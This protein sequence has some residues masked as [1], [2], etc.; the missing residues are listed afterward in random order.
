VA[1]A[2]KLGR[3]WI[4]IDITHL[5]IALQ[6]YR[7]QGMFPGITFKVV[8]EPEDMGAAR[9]LAS[10]D[11]YQFQWWALSLVRAKPLGAQGDSKI[12][13]K[14]S[15]KGIDGI[16]NFIDDH[17][18]KPKRIIVQV[19]SGKVKSG[20]IRDLVG[21]IQRESGAIGVFITLE[22]PS[23]D[24]QTEAA[25]AGYYQSP[26]WNKDYPR[27]QILTIDQLLNKA[28]IQMPPAEYGTFKQAQP[29]QLGGDQLGLDDVE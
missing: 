21:T 10:E 11:R 6:K 13:K 16:I 3:K 23:K 12:G 19:K 17:T 24:M 26:G 4:G 25:T 2:Q 22:S 9:Q 29:V 8:G 20:D 14:G 1:A 27:I 15:D 18:G 28:A 7:L 5:S